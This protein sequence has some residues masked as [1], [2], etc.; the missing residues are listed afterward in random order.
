MITVDTEDLVSSS[1]GILTIL[2]DDL[3]KALLTNLHLCHLLLPPLKFQF[4]P[5]R[6]T[7][8]CTYHSGLPSLHILN[9]SVVISF[10]FLQI[11]SCGINSFHGQV[12]F[13]FFLGCC[14]PWY[15]GWSWFWFSSEWSG[16]QLPR[17]CRTISL[18][19]WDDMLASLNTYTR[20]AAARM[21]CVDRHRIL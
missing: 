18:P 17:F 10:R 1:Y 21:D 3:K 16:G 13:F 7:V 11:P 19:L 12:F 6:S 14:C 2:S 5:D 20:I 8:N 15:S 9:F 4:R